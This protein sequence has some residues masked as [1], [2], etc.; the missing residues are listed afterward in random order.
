MQSVIEARPPYVR[1][2]VRAIKRMKSLAEGGDIYFVNQD[3]ALITAHGS[4]DTVEKEVTEY[5]ERLKKEVRDQRYPQL[6]LD[7]FVANYKAW[8]NDQEPP[9]N[10]F[11][12][13]EWPAASPAEI[14]ML[15][16]LRVLTVEDLAAA[17]EELLNRV[18]MGARALKTKA[19]QWLRTK[20]DIGPVV[21]EIS[22]LKTAVAALQAQL[23]A[24]N[25]RATAAEEAARAAQIVALPQAM[26]QAPLE[27]R[28]PR[29]QDNTD[30]ALRDVL[31]EIGED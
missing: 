1:F 28:L 15:R 18:G 24:A 26:P 6:W 30:A 8:K 22:A 19:E 9:L 10:G 7:A 23:S 27:D 31:A 17:N 13:R 4:K 14:K 5:I 16:E 29:A 3:F 20:S 21:A 2:E 11:D 12:I 25:A